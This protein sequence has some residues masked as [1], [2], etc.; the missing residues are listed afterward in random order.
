MPYSRTRRGVYRHGKTREAAEELSTAAPHTRL[1]AQ[2]RKLARQ[3][4]NAAGAGW[5]VARAF[6]P[7]E[8]QTVRALGRPDTSQRDKYLWHRKYEVGFVTV[9]SALFDST[10]NGIAQKSTHRAIREDRS[11]GCSCPCAPSTC[12][13]RSIDSRLT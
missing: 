6:G 2:L 10:R 3:S 13:S 8:H 9:L 1:E 11:L 7:E 12:R 5:Q 4:R